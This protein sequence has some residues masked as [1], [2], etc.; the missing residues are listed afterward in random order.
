VNIGGKYC[1]RS[2]RDF[3]VLSENPGASGNECGQG[4]PSLFEGGEGGAPSEITQNGG[5]PSSTRNVPFDDQSQLKITAHTHFNA[6]R[7]FFSP[8]FQSRFIS[9]SCRLLLLL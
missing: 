5:G 7:Q 8:L 4:S 6:F 9:I 1:L 3:C 2:G